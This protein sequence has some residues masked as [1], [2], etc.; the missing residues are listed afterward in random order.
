MINK[1]KNWLK[2]NQKGAVFGG[3]AGWAMAIAALTNSGGFF[4][5]IVFGVSGPVCNVVSYFCSTDLLLIILTTS[6]GAIAGSIIDN[7]R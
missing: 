3:L 1:I 5:K 6:I 4:G 7:Y 2:K